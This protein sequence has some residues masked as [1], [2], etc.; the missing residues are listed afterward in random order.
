MKKNK[1]NTY[2]Q[3]STH[4]DFEWQVDPKYDFIYSK[5]RIDSF[6]CEEVSIILDKVNDTMGLL[7]NPKESIEATQDLIYW[8]KR[9]LLD[10]Y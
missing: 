2:E 6:T 3:S 7:N 9:D 4:K 5:K 8:I 10:T 1:G